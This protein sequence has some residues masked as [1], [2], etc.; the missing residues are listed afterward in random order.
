MKMLCSTIE[1]LS[2]YKNGNLF[3]FAIST[4]KNGRM[5]KLNYF[6]TIRVG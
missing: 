2:K 6:K 5:R 1:Y 4:V 3:N